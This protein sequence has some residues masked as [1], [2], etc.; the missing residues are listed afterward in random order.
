M[1]ENNVVGFVKSTNSEMQAASILLFER[2]RGANFCYLSMGI[3]LE[4][5][6]YS[7]KLR[8]HVVAL[9]RFAY[10]SYLLVVVFQCYNGVFGIN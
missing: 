3:R 4:I 6:R 5:S 1:C 7:L 8:T 9:W 10:L 2:S